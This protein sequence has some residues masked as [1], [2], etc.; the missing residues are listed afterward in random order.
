MIATRSEFGRIFG[1]LCHVVALKQ[2]DKLFAALQSIVLTVFAFDSD[3]A[4]TTILEIREAISVYFG[5]EV[6]ERDVRTAVDSL[7]GDTRMMLQSNAYM[8]SLQTSV[9]YQQRI[10]EANTLESQVKDEWLSEIEDLEI[11][12]AINWHESMWNC[13]TS[14]LARAFYQHGVQTVQLLDPR[15]PSNADDTAS[16]QWYMAE[17]RADH[18]KDIP[19][20]LLAEAIQRFFL[21][22]STQKTRFVIQLLDGTFTYFALTTDEVVAQYLTETI[23]PVK[24]FLD[25]NFIFGLF[26]LH[27]NPLN[28]VSKELINCI[29]TND[30]QFTLYYTL[31]TLE[32]I[33]RTLAYY[34]DRLRGTTWTTKTSRIALNNPF[35]R[36]IE[37]RFHS[38]N[39]ESPIS[40][41]Y[42]LSQFEQMTTLL[43]DKG[44]IIFD[45]DISL[46]EQEQYDTISSYDEYLT[47]RRGFSKRYETLRHDVLIWQI[48]QLARSKTGYGLDSGAFFLTVDYYFSSFERR[49]LTT[50]N[51]IPVSIFP[52]QM[53][54]LL[55]PFIVTSERVDKQFVETFA[56]PEF[57]IA[58]ED[59]SETASRVL[60]MINSFPDVSEES[61]IRIMT[62][63]MAM[64]QFKDLEESSDDFRELF[65]S[66]VARENKRLLE[67]KSELERRE[68]SR[69]ADIQVA[70]ARSQEFRQQLKLVTQEK[71]QLQE[72]SN[73]TIETL[74]SE[75]DAKDTEIRIL[76]QKARARNDLLKAT[77][78]LLIA[79]LTT[80]L[81]VYLFLLDRLIRHSNSIWIVVTVASAICLLTMRTGLT[82][83]WEWFATH[84]N[85][86]SLEYST[87]ILFISVFVL[88]AFPQTS[89]SNIAVALFAAAC[90]RI[91]NKID[92]NENHNEQ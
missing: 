44:F 2:D 28:E 90:L 36:G 61:A 62:N 32:E 53:L 67:R 19:E 16:L 65:E 73:N 9:E 21:S 75:A 48:V 52:N 55:R 34:G 35:T 43:E 82:N 60:R 68:E 18:C 13:L 78:F 66:E 58:H 12:N 51:R 11:S 81:F 87:A 56:L 86:R 79:S 70:N 76:Q 63:N 84:P 45:E 33:E 85:K 15:I 37:R 92:R 40:P 74:K 38:L 1:H 80:G 25:S 30:F 17:A 8:L 83:R 59:Y 47:D 29:A 71:T 50:R 69:E 27:D 39:S 4:P 5:I 10:I 3:F 42:F 64:E 14:Y 41:D 72:E 31:Q 49:T 24:I 57:R 20:D 46:N 89:A 7:I 26:D 91:V 22:K 77:V 6:A 54:Q 23:P 88:L